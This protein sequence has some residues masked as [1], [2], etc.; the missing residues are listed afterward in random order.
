MVR[1]IL[2]SDL[3]ETW[4]MWLTKLNAKMSK[5]LRAQ[6]D[7]S[8]IIEKIKCVQGLIE[9]CVE[10]VFMK[11]R[12]S[13]FMNFTPGKQKAY[14]QK[15][16]MNPKNVPMKKLFTRLNVFNSYLKCFPNSE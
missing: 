16:L 14:M 2:H 6:V 15:G 10:K 1:H 5:W 4:D 13:F 8:I 12:D 9:G 11:I 3:K 7:E